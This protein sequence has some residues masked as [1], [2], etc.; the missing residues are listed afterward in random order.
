[1]QHGIAGA[2]SF[3]NTLQ[4]AVQ[5]CELSSCDQFQALACNGERAWSKKLA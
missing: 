5:P 1:M 3:S 2:P 4:V